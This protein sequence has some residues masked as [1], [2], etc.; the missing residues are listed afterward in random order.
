MEQIAYRRSFSEETLQC[1]ELPGFSFAETVYPA[2]LKMPRHTHELARFSLVL[3]GGYTE[4]YG[5][6]TRNCQPATLI[7]HPPGEDHA[8]DFGQQQAR[9]FRVEV[10]SQSLEHVRE[11]SE[12]LDSPAA[13]E[14]G[15][16][17]QLATKLY[18]EARA[19]DSASP[20]AIE[21]LVLEVI[22]DASRRKDS[23]SGARMTDWLRRAVELL[24]ANFADNLTLADVAEA[25]GVHPVYLARE[26]R[27]R[28]Q[29]TVGEY[30]RRLRVENACRELTKSD[31]TLVEIATSAG[32]YDQS[33]FTRTFKQ[34]TGMTPG[35]FRSAFQKG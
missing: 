1:R 22:A 35:E 9:I 21:G 19:S 25:A 4:R 8:V 24:H 15:S 31:A 34:I 20:L 33:H 17:S 6:K 23:H 27:K 10:K 13:F 12:I 26:F 5:R 30:V 11:C 32:F 7:F 28:H 2:N 18:R 29:C 14:G 16:S 3:Q